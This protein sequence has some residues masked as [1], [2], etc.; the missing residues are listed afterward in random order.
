MIKKL[1]MMFAAVAAAFGA[2]AETET[3]GNCDWSY[4]I[5]DDSASVVGVSSDVKNITI[6]SVLGGR[7]V[8]SIADAAFYGQD[9]IIGVTIPNGI[10]NIGHHAFAYCT[11]ISKVTIPNSVVKVG[12]S[13]FSNCSSLN[14]VVIGSG[15]TSLGAYA[16][17][18]CG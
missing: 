6:P 9:W 1:M 17:D 13:A 4:M 12:W 5:V 2:W 14:C 16:F 10:T 7:P 18:D 15:L 3:V 8:K 11:S